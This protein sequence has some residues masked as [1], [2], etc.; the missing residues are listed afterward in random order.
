MRISVIYLENINVR[1]YMGHM[2][3]NSGNTACCGITLIK[4]HTVA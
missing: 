2:S 4:Q 3:H 1:T